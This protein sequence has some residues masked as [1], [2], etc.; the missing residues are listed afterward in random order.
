MGRKRN[1]RKTG[2]R[3]ERI[4]GE[5]L[6]GQGY[7]ILQYNYR[8]RQ[9]EI[10]IVARDGEYL[11]FCEVKF[12]TDSSGGLPEEAVDFKKQRVISKC[13]LYYITV[14]GL[15]G[16]PCRFDVVGILG[17]TEGKEGFCDLNIRLYKNAFDY[18]E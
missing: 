5:Y 11:V 13:A 8:C 9:G 7:R 17:G 14:N 15:S 1:K 4:A 6:E 12:R 10:D 3:Y 2:A 16:T 18:R